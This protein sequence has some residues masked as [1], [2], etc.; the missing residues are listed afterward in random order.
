MFVNI[1]DLNLTLRFIKPLFFPNA[2]IPI[3]IQASKR[4]P[5]TTFNNCLLLQ[6]F[7]AVCDDFYG[8]LFGILS[9]NLMLSWNLDKKSRQ[10]RVTVNWGKHIWGQETPYAPYTSSH[11]GSIQI[12]HTPNNLSTSFGINH[13][14]K[15]NIVYNDDTKSSLVS[16]LTSLYF[17]GDIIFLVI[18]GPV[19]K[20]GKRISLR[21]CRHY[22]YVY[23]H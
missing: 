16:E 12:T 10:T 4:D 20:G 13:A 18:I 15:E 5:E 22:I 2:Y 3:L 19:V 14:L 17:S 11:L 21:Q 9:Q 1:Y 23:R 8:R 6:V 7:E